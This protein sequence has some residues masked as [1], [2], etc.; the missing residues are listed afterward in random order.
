MAGIQAIM[1]PYSKGPDTSREHGPTQVSPATAR[2]MTRHSK[3]GSRCLRM[4]AGVTGSDPRDS[5]SLP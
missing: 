4:A 1:S 5:D 3:G 2:A